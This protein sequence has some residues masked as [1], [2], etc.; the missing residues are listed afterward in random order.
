MKLL[1]YV[2]IEESEELR[3]IFQRKNALRELMLSFANAPKDMVENNLYYEKIVDD[4]G[5]CNQRMMEWWNKTAS[6]YGWKYS[7]QDSW[8]IDFE[9]REVYLTV[10]NSQE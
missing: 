2:T 9:T 5:V 3:K 4:L 1:G 8:H 10:K 7:S 6:E